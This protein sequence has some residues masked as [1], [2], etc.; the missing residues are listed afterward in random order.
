MKKLTP[1]QLLDAAERALSRAE[2]AATMRRQ[3]LTEDVGPPRAL[4]IALAML[5]LY[6]ADGLIRT[7][8]VAIRTGDF[9]SLR[10]PGRSSVAAKRY[11]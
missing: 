3:E 8:R 9:D 7:S 4:D 6:E 11:K 1:T 2:C 10:L 5:A